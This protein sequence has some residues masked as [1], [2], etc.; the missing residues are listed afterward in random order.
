[1]RPGETFS[2]KAIG[3]KNGKSVGD[4]TGLGTITWQ[5]SNPQVAQVNGPSV[6]GASLG[7]ATVT[8]QYGGT[9]SQ[10]ASVNVVESIADNLKVE[11]KSP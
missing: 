8:A 6:T 1:M 7:Q 10:P 11:P 4:I 2:L 9:T 5:S 3:Q